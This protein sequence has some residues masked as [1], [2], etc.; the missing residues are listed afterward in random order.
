VASERNS[1]TLIIARPVEAPKPR[2]RGEACLVLLHPPGPDIGK[3]TPLSKRAYIVGRDAEVDLVISR[4]SV[5]RQH[6]QLTQDEAGEWW[7]QDLGSTNG[8]FV[9]EERITR[10]CLTDGDQVRFGDAIFKFLSGANIESAYH[11]E[12]YRMTILDGLTGIHNKRYFLE[13]LERELAGAHRHRHPLS[14]VMFDVDHFKKVNDERGHLAGDHVLKEI[15][16]RIRPRIRREDLYARYGGEEFAC[17]LASTNLDGA[18]QFAEHIRGLIADKNIV[19][20][21]QPFTV[22][23][24]LGVATVWNEPGVDLLTLIKRA[25]DNLY[26]AKRS[27]RNKVVP[28]VDEIGP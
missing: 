2:E 4:S 5:S 17:I 7:V 12:I 18:V 8:T 3:R 26:T 6:S 27:G 24:S 16:T 21:G 25:D 14:L 20:D 19:F 11:E 28:G 22:T 10:R 13:F 9:N 15:A 23:I 1:G